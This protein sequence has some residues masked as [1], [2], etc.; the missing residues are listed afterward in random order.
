MKQV[1]N[2]GDFSPLE[3]RAKG[4]SDWL[5]KNG[6]GC[7]EEQKH[8][9]QNTQERIYWHYGYM[10]AL[11]D[12]VCYLTGIRPTAKRDSQRQDTRSDFPAACP[13][14]YRYPAD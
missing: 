3:T 9:D 13:D 14:G 6:R 1:D 11:V 4:I 2:V 8:L 12:V 5:K 7:F 10:S